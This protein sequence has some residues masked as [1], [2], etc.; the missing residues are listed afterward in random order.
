MIL[1]AGFD[2]VSCQF[3]A[4]CGFLTK[5]SDSVLKE[6]NDFQLVLIFLD[7][8]LTCSYWVNLRCK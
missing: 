1:Q 8:R 7:V 6:V 3:L 5:G 4:A 2:R